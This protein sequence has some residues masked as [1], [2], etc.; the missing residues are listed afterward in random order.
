MELHVRHLILARTSCLE[1]DRLFV[2]L[3]VVSHFHYNSSAQTSVR[4]KIGYQ[5]PDLWSTTSDLH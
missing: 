5:D 4:V 3:A 2:K 1:R